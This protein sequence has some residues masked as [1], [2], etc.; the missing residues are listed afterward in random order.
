ML[1]I[2]LSKELHRYADK[3]AHL[4]YFFC[5]STEPTLNNA[6][7]VL[8]GLLWKLLHESHALCHRFYLKFRDVGKQFFEGPNAFSNLSLTLSELLSDPALLTVYLLVDALDECDVEQ[9]KI[10]DF[11]AKETTKASSKAKWLVSS[12]NHREIGEVLQLANHRYTLSLEL[13]AEHVAK[14][15]KAFIEYKV[16]HLAKRKAYGA[17]LQQLVKDCLTQKADST[18]LWVALVCKE[19]EKP[20]A[21]PRKALA[22]LETF[23]SGLQPLYSRMLDQLEAQ[24]DEDRDLS[25][26]IMRCV[27]LTYRPLRL[28]ELSIL[29]ALPE[30]MANDEQY[31]IEQVGMCGSFIEIRETTQGNTRGK[32]CY[33]VHQSAKDY[34]VKGSGE[35]I[36]TGTIEEEHGQIADRS[37]DAMSKTLRMD[38]CSLRKPGASAAD[39]SLT[40]PLESISYACCYWVNHIAEMNEWTSVRNQENTVD[41]KDDGKVHKFLLRSLLHWMEALAIIQQLNTGILALQQLA[42]MTKVSDTNIPSYCC[43]TNIES[44]AFEQGSQL[45]RP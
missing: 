14:A 19:L 29:A 31:L 28:E 11:I 35:R 9:Q 3:S 36:F 27:V 21:L 23:P 6:T 13:N 41:M 15:V 34:F 25:R 44:G 43:M 18:F 40:Q 33:F 39:A 45:F 24:D 26:S 32:T 16:K 10:L 1:M 5:Q 8:R 2:A 20:K 42:R 4:A 30:D 12:R 7:A 22:T 37:L 17:S 38:I